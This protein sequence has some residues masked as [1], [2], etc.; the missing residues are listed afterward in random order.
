M[1]VMSNLGVAV[2]EPDTIRVLH[3]NGPYRMIATRSAHS[4]LAYDLFI[5]AYYIRNGWMPIYGYGTIF[6]DPHSA[7]LREE[8]RQVVN[9]TLEQLGDRPRVCWSIHDFT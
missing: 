4:R 7:E 1:T 5:E 9:E 8:A 2:N 6:E 3:T